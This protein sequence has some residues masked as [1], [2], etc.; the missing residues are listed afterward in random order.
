[1]M[2][3][4]HALAG[5]LVG[6]LALPLVPALAPTALAA[7]FLGGLA[8]DLDIFATHRR[9]LHFPVYGPPVAALLAVP[10]ILVPGNVTVF[11]AVFAGAAALHAAMDVAG[12]GLGL[13]P[14]LQEDDRAVYSHALGRWIAPWGPIEYDGAPADFLLALALGLPLLVV[15][16]GPVWWLV[17]GLLGTAAGYVLVRKRLVAI[18]SALTDLV[19]R[20]LWILLPGRMLEARRKD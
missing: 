18:L 16:S 19:P 12:G 5:L 7:G 10:A 15:G 9:T 17:V 3:M 14:W 1:M 20:P 13:Q 11:V 4:T 2:A 6:A 8:P